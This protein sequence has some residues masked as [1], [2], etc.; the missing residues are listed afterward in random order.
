MFIVWAIS[1]AVD[2][3]QSSFSGQKEDRN[4]QS[5]R[6]EKIASCRS[7]PHLRQPCYTLLY[8][9]A[10]SNST[11]LRELMGQIG[12]DPN[13]ILQ[14]DSPTDLDS[15]L[16]GNPTRSL[17][18]VIFD[19]ERDPPSFVL[20]VNTTAAYWK[21]KY[22]DPNKLLL[23]LQTAIEEAWIKLSSPKAQI[24]IFVQKFPHPS[25]ST[26]S[27]SGSV[28]P[29][30]ILASIMI[31]FVCLLNDLVSEKESG[32]RHMMETQGLMMGSYWLSVSSSL[33]QLSTS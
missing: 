13:E 20:Q 31:N 4:P 25:L 7:S 30:F 24:K 11:I 22:R 5:E 28:L 19:L 18:S 2:L 16:L 8:S 32:M 29:V 21:G 12:L 15:W 33:L 14:F 26:T 23:S 1:Q 27:V 3:N 6:V 17:S 10:S 9:S